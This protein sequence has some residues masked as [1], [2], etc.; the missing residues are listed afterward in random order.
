MKAKLSAMAAVVAALA[1]M[2][3]CAQVTNAIDSANNYSSWPQA[4]NNGTGF[5][6]WS[7]NNTQPNG[8]FSGEFLGSSYTGNGG[9]LNSANGNAFGFY[10]N[11]GT[12]AEAQAIAPFS[13]GALTANQTFSVQMQNHFIGDTGGQIG[14]N[15]QNS[16]GNNIFQFYFNGGASDYYI[17]VWT[18]IAAGI[19]IDAGVGYTSSPL[20]LDYSQGSGNSWAFSI[21]EGN[22]LLATLTSASTGDSIWQNG[23]SKLTSSAST[24]GT[25]AIRTT[26]LSLTI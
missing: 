14:F 3:A 19:Q 23:I 8:G 18:G 20:T 24:A 21:L 25:R 11:S 5:G 15:L 1:S 2:S 12:F 4:G 13:A 17:N 6:N 7:Y 26:M 22:T 10:A 16:S 9:G